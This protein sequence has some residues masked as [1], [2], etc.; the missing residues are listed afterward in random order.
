[1]DDKTIKGAN[2]HYFIFD[3]SIAGEV[4]LDAKITPELKQEGN[5]R[6]LVRALQDMRKKMGFT[7]S[8]VIALNFETN[9]MGKA[10]IGKFEADIKKTVLV[11]KIEFKANDGQEIKIDE[12]VFKVKIDK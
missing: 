3:N 10:L 6:E 9:D 5:Y 2:R 8:D 12:L 1:M 4:E 11:S 7:P